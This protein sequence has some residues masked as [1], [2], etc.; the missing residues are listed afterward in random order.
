M[1]RTVALTLPAGRWGEGLD[2]TSP[3][4][5]SARKELAVPRSVRTVEP[6]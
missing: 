4:H 2:Q 1:L 6:C 5:H 3:F